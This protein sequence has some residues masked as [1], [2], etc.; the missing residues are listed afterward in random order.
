M[1]IILNVHVSPYIAVFAVHRTIKFYLLGIYLPSYLLEYSW[2]YKILNVHVSSYIAVHCVH[3]RF[4]LSIFLPSCLCLPW[5]LLDVY[6]PW[7]I[8][9]QHYCCGYT[10]GSYSLC[11]CSWYLIMHRKN[12]ADMTGKILQ[13]HCNFIKDQWTILRI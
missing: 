13:L 5:V 10:P 6:N 2:M 8:S 3:T 7:C 12:T 9:L 4:Y 1:Y 11:P